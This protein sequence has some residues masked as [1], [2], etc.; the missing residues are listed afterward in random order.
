MSVALVSIFSFFF[1]RQKPALA[2]IMGISLSIIGL[3]LISID[4]EFNFVFGPGEVLILC[5]AVAF[6]LHIVCISKF[7]PNANVTNLAIVQLALTSLLSLIFMPIAHEA[8][9]S[10]PL[11]VW[12][13]GLFMGVADIAFCL[14]MMNWVQQFLSITLATFS[15]SLHPICP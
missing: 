8:F 13:A 4:N 7:A 10:P 6:A 9:I 15:Y 3:T 11:I 12:G 14:L 5:C 2:A 1:L